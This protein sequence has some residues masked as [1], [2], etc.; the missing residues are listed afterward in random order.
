MEAVKNL[1]LLSTFNESPESLPAYLLCMKLVKKGHH[2]YVTTTSTGDELNAELK[3]AKELSLKYEGKI[4]L[5]KPRFHD[6]EKPSPEWIQNLHREY[7]SYLLEYNVNCIFGTLPGTAQTAVELKERMKCKVILLATCKL[8]S[9]KQNLKGDIIKSAIATDEVWSMGPEIYTHYK[10][11]F[12]YSPQIRHQER[13]LLPDIDPTKYWKQHYKTDTSEAVRLI[14]VWIP[15]IEF[16]H[17]GTK[18]YSQGRD[19]E[20]YY[21]LSTALGELNAAYNMDKVQWN[22]HGLEQND[23]KTHDIQNHAKPHELN[24]NALGV[25]TSTDSLPWADYLAFIVPDHKDETFN[26]LALNA[27]CHGIPTLVSS[28]SSFGRFL[29]SLPCSEKFRAVVNLTGDPQHDTAEWSKKINNE[30]LSAQANPQEW[31]TTLSKYLLMNKHPW[32]PDLGNPTSLQEPV[33]S[34]LPLD[35]S[36]MS[37]TSD[38]QSQILHSANIT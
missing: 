11:I 35:N 9:S 8:E 6:D 33:D 34:L 26:F 14:S 30:I 15:P 1:V 22:I 4:E 23:H 27:I 37:P 36:E 25:K 19:I 12:Q 5:L 24:I 2:V 10:D 38:Q 29:L 18:M 7:F 32:E 16:F 28:Q 20:K 3:R 13:V 17:Y 21:T 31:A